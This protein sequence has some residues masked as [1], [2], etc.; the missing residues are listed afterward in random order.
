MDLAADLVNVCLS[1]SSKK[2]DAGRLDNEHATFFVLIVET[3]DKPI[4][5]NGGKIIGGKEDDLTRMESQMRRIFWQL[6]DNLFES[7]QMSE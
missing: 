5:T 4:E 1:E 6:G 7:K 2:T 3:K